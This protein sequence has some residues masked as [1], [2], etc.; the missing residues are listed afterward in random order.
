MIADY[1]ILAAAA[2]EPPGALAT[3]RGSGI[4]FYDLLLIIGAALAIGLILALIIKIA[5]RSRGSGKSSSNDSSTGILP[6]SRRRR[7]EHRPRNPTLAETGGLPP[8]RQEP[9]PQT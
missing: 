4:L 1:A 8:P 7:R 6:G 5:Y 2:P 3:S 9:P